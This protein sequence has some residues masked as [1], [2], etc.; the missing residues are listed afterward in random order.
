MT[1]DPTKGGDTIEMPVIKV[2]RNLQLRP[3]ALPHDPKSYVLL[4]FAVGGG[5][6]KR[7]LMTRIVTLPTLRKINESKSFIYICINTF[8]M[9]YVI[10]GTSIVIHRVNYGLLMD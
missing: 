3:P 9:Q 6:T 8:T 10:R 2:Y 7:V 5:V 4:F 1:F